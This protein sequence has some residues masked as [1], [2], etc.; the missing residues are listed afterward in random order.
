M[1]ILQPCSASKTTRFFIW[2][3]CP[4][5]P[6]AVMCLL[7]NSINDLVI[8]SDC[9]PAELNS[10]SSFSVTLSYLNHSGIVDHSTTSLLIIYSTFTSY[11]RKWLELPISATISSIILMNLNMG[12]ALSF[13][14]LRLRLHCTGT[15]W[16]RIKSVTDRPPVYTSSAEEVRF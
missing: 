4:S 5:V 15:V 13:H 8:K 11:V 1:N 16:S 2:G 9:L 3:H 10:T 7:L 6:H 12:L 14:L